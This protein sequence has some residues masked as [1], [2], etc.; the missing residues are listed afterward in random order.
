MGNQ[1]SVPN[2]NSKIRKIKK[3]NPNNQRVNSKNKSRTEYKQ[4]I[5]PPDQQRHINQNQHTNQPQ[6][7]V[8]HQRNNIVPIQR[9]QEYNDFSNY[10]YEIK[11][12]NS[13]LNSML[14]ERSMMQN[15]KEDCV[16]KT[17]FFDRPSNSNYQLSNPKPTF[18]NIE[19]NYV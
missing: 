5:H 18:D 2:A 6:R 17:Q 7:K 8:I 3:K 12:K 14:V 16:D 11:Q 15:K 9:T 10:N 13:D 4:N 1:E 19:F